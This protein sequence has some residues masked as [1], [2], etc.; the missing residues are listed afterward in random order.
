MV[1]ETLTPDQVQTAIRQAMADT[2]LELIAGVSTRPDSLS[3]H[4]HL[5]NQMDVTLKVYTGP[6]A[7]SDVEHEIRLLGL[8][9]SET[10]VPTPRVLYKAG[11]LAGTPY[12]WALLTRVSGQPLARVADLLDDWELETIGYETGRYLSHIHQVPVDEFGTLFVRGPHNHP[13]EKA[14]QLAQVGE[15]LVA[16]TQ[17]VL[18]P[19]E[20]AAAFRRHLAET[21]LLNRRQACLIH[22]DLGPDKIMVE[23]EGTGYHVTGILGF[24][25]AQGGSPEFDMA[26][27]FNWPMAEAP[28]FQKSFLDG[29]A[30]SGELPVHFWERLALYQAVFC[31]NKIQ[32]LCQQADPNVIQTCKVR[33]IDYTNRWSGPL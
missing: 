27:L 12:P 13:R 3:Y 17:N 8:L 4:L 22:G 5:S 16:C 11:E 19:A 7:G 30:E 18:L 31:L 21:D 25:R 33:F 32:P 29:Y 26:G 2:D 15:W 6:Q 20:T 28:S 10:G 9:T 24:D 23:K 1:L 14:Y